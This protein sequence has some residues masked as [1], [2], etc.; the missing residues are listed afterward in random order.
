MLRRA[1]A[2]AVLLAGVLAPSSAYADDGPA[3]GTSPGCRGSLLSVTVC[4]SDTTAA[5]GTP[6]T[7]A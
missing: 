7:D 5:G 3:L 1:A 6:G 2:A 4:A